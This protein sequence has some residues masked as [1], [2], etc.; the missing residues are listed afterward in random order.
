ME[1]IKPFYEKPIDRSIALAIY[2]GTFVWQT[3]SKKKMKAKEI[4]LYEVRV[5][6]L[7]ILFHLLSSSVG[8]AS[9]AVVTMT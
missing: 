5:I 3:A 7:K 4:S 9:A 1:E 6:L 2:N 8:I